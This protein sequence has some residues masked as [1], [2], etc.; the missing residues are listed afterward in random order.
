MPSDS[1]AM[2][3]CGKRVMV[4]AKVGIKGWRL[5][6]RRQGRESFEG[7]LL[8]TERCTSSFY[9]CSLN[10]FSDNPRILPIFCR[11][12]NGE[13]EKVSISLILIQSERSC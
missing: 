2:T 11:Y 1:E 7:N 12:Q 8:F 3:M 4:E 6:L 9:M 5:D 13:V 10:S